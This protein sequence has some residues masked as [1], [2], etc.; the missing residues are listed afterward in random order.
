MGV[1]A[2]SLSSTLI[3]KDSVY[4]SVCKS[5]TSDLVKKRTFYLQVKPNDRDRRKGRQDNGHCFLSL[6]N[7]LH[8][9]IQAAK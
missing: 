3:M 5:Q 1:E 4:I 7:Q 8:P 6:I 9:N 2:E